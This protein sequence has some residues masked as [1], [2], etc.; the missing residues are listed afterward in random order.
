MNYMI[1]NIDESTYA[2]LKRYA[3]DNSVSIN[4]LINIILDRAIANNEFRTLHQVVIDEIH[5]LK[6]TNN[7]LVTVIKQQNE[8]INSLTKELS[9]II[10]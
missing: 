4:E 3:E 1:R 5:L 2:K 10:E 6:I 7:Q 9:K 8:S